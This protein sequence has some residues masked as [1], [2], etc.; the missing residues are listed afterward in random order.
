MGGAPYTLLI[1][2]IVADVL[3]R[4][5][6]L[7]LLR[8]LLHFDA[9]QYAKEAY[10]RPLLIAVIAIIG[11]VL[12]SQLQMETSMEKVATIVV[13][14]LCTMVMIYFIGLTSDERHQICALV[15]RRW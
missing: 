14:T 13:C 7:V 9:W 4:V 1:L 5:V 6:Q 8:T 15:K 11:F 12:H 10:G 2:F 3:Q